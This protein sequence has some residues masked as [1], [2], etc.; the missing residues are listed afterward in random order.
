MPIS[1]NN[2]LS[3]K[4]HS[5]CFIETGTNKGKSVDKAIDC[6]FDLI[7]SIEFGQSLFDHCV[8]KYKKNDNVSIF[9]GSSAN[10]LKDVIDDVDERI[11]FW[12]DAHYSG[13]GTTMDDKVC[14]VIEELDAILSHKIKNHIILIDDVRLFKITGRDVKNFSGH[15]E[16]TIDQVISKLKEINS[17][18]QI[19][20]IDGY[21]S[22]DVLVALPPDIST[23]IINISPPKDIPEHL[24]DEF[25][26]NGEI[27]VK[28]R[29]FNESHSIK[30]EWSSEYI[31]LF[32]SKAKNRG[33]GNY[34]NIDKMIYSLLSDFPFKGKSVL[35]TGSFRPFYE[36]LC[37]AEESSEIVVSEY[38]VPQCRDTRISY[39]HV[40]D[41]NRKFDVILSI[42]SVEHDGLGRYG[43]EINPSGDI[44]A[45]S[46]I[47]NSMHDDSVLF[48][49]VPIGKDK[50]EWNAHRIYGRIR[51]PM[52][53]N[54]LKVVWSSF[55]VEGINDNI[56]DSV[57]RSNQ[58]MI[59]RKN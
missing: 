48:L 56:L 36:G 16:L 11:L 37:I 45:M 15:F 27:E 20:Y 28:H 8:E 30:K 43:D 3:F 22:N 17:D 25:T 29:Y 18:Y 42:S 21:V 32:V 58:L 53:L 38:N 26:L 10:I 2:L 5:N 24:K 23:S 19:L 46:K 34:A 31:N 54:G 13:S 39:L 47:I 52:L 51:L 7:K 49:S 41:I 14:P 4:N 35:I 33:P 55:D 44:E 40:N 50:I 6:G 1:A 59:L 12:L 57:S 9:H